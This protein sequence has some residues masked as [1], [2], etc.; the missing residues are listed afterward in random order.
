MS[1]GSLSPRILVLALLVLAHA[2]TPPCAGQQ[3]CQIQEILSSDGAAGDEFGVAV[4]MDNGRVVIGARW[5]D[6]N[7]GSAYVFRWDGVQ[8]VFEQKLTPSDGSTGD[9]FGEVVAMSADRIVVGAPLH[10]NA[11]GAAYVYVYN[12]ATW[13]QEQKLVASDGSSGD[14]FGDAAAIDADWIVIGRLAMTTMDPIADPLISTTMT[15]ANGSRR[16]R[17]P[18]RAARRATS[19]HEAAPSLPFW[20]HG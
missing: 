9:E 8:W 18:P 11:T 12:G 17:S 19:S 4:A 6:G 13:A 10:N 7:R 2:G 16:R 15:A 14:S 5:D 1:V 3:A 20:A